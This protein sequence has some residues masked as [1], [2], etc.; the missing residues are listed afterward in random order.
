MLTYT[1]IVGSQSVQRLML[2]NG[3]EHTLSFTE[4]LDT[5]NEEQETDFV[6]TTD[7]VKCVNIDDIAEIRPGM[8]PIL[9]AL[10]STWQIT[11]SGKFSYIIDGEELPLITIVSSEYVIALPVANLSQRNGVL[12]KF[13]D[14]VIYLQ[15]K[16]MD[17]T[18]ISL[19]FYD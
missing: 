18:G 7:N 8:P 4:V 10:S 12:K 17:I 14:F 15:D 19:P 2:Y 6:P 1:S 11:C 16:S 5:S 3:E 9:C 13:Q